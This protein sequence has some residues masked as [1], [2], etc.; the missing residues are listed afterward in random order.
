MPLASSNRIQKCLA[1]IE[2]LRR[3]A[4]AEQDPF[5]KAELRDRESQWLTILESYQVVEEAGMDLRQIRLGRANPPSYRSLG[6]GTLLEQLRGLLSVAIEYADGNARAAL[7]LAD[8][9][10]RTLHHVA[11]MTEAYARCVDGFAVGEDSLACGLAVAQRLPVITPDVSEEPRWRPWLWL[12][13]EFHYRACWSFPVSGPAGEVLGSLAIYYPHR[14]E[15]TTRDLDMAA[16]LSRTAASI[17]SRA[18]QKAL[19]I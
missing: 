19:L 11:G 16:L 18:N 9:A 14:R 3:R 17:L 10:G 2:D 12:A 1:H 4:D 15:A 13:E 5:L 7:Y 6:R 8:P